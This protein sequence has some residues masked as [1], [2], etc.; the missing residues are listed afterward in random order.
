MRLNGT[1]RAL[2]E[3]DPETQ[4]ILLRR[5]HSRINAFN[6]NI[7]FLLKCNM[8]IKYIG[9]GQAAK[10]LVYYI[11]DYITKSSLPVHIGFDALKHT[12]QQ[13]S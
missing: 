10:A 12:I 9:S 1:T 5:L 13:N 6:D 2:T 4:S 3:V 11:T 8:D 7:I